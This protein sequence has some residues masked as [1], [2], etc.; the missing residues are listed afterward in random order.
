MCAYSDPANLQWI[1][2]KEIVVSERNYN[3]VHFSVAYHTELLET[4]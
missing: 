1:C 4:I 2:P 3:G